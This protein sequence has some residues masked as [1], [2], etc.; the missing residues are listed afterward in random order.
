MRAQSAQLTGVVLTSP[1]EKP[2]ADAEIL[3]ESLKLATR[4]D[5]DG[6]YTVSGLP[7]GKHEVV[8]R[9]IGYKPFIANLVVGTANKLDADFL[10]EV[11]PATLATFDI[12]ADLLKRYARTL[13]DFESR[14]KAGFGKFLTPDVMEKNS[15]LSFQAL[16]A[17][18]VAGVKVIDVQGYKVASSGRGI[19]ICPV[20]IFVDHMLMYNGGTVF[21]DVGMLNADRIIGIEYYTR[22][23]TPMEFLSRPRGTPGGAGCGTLII[24]MKQ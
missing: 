9:H 15:H 4:S 7:R 12:K 14:R 13:V 22:M 3:F 5:A 6:R 23:M 21:Y 17:K 11:A 2:L 16:L 24:W 18:F 10:L 19:G 1:D 20:Q 8:V